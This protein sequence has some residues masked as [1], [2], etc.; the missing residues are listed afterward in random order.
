MER[1]REKEA[2]GEIRQCNEGRWPF[3]M[4]DED[5]EGN[6]VVTVPL[7]KFLDSSLLHVDA[8]PAY[9]TIIIKG[10]VLRLR[11]PEEV[12]SD[13]GTAQ[14]S[15]TTGELVLKL[16]KVAKPRRLGGGTR[17][18]GAGAGS[19]AGAGAGTGAGGGR[20]PLKAASG[21]HARPT[22]SLL[23][24]SNTADIT[25][26]TKRFVAPAKMGDAML[27]AAADALEDAD[28]ARGAGAAAADARPGR[29]LLPA[30]FDE[31]DVPPLE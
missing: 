5:G 19:A 21:R 17:A 3:T 13:A 7:P 18:I 2:S 24:K 4:S 25:E 10:K 14:R 26:R 12:N 22:K 15:A 30:G 16:P 29:Q 6:V 27:E 23:K 1:A 31:S 11:F 8:H 20:E 28:S 9:V